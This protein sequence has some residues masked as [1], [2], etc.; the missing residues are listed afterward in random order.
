MLRLGKEC[1]R[2]T[3]IDDQIGAPTGAELLADATAHAIRATLADASKAGLYHLVAGGETSWNGY[4][5][6]VLEQ[7]RLLGVEIKAVAVDP[8][9]TTAFP[10]PAARP[11]NSRLDTR[12]FQAAFGLALPQWQAGVARMLRETNS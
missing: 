6:F 9:P 4:A 1:D 7:A 3:V 8:V 10:T 11:L 12:K 2:L 5:R